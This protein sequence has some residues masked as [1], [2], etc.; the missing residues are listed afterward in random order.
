MK[1]R[2]TELGQKIKAWRLAELRKLSTQQDVFFQCLI[3]KPKRTVYLK[4]SSMQDKEFITL[5]KSFPETNT[6][7]S[8]F[9]K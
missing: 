5:V 6:S 4:S 8:R 9:K 2:I 3:M 1:P 7:P